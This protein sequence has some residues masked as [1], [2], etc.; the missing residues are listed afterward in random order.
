MPPVSRRIACSRRKEWL[1]GWGWMAGMGGQEGGAPHQGLSA[2]LR[3]SVAVA[4]CI[5]ASPA[6]RRVRVW[7][8]CRFM[9]RSHR[10]RSGR[11]AGGNVDTPRSMS[12]VFANESPSFMANWR[13]GKAYLWPTPFSCLKTPPVTFPGPQ[14]SPL[15]RSGGHQRTFIREPTVDRARRVKARPAC[16]FSDIR[17]PQSLYRLASR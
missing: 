1:R 15:H 2:Q 12:L 5:P 16:T 3:C 6:A 9:D 4:G 8:G 11:L 17:I 14:S 13:G 7:G 10:L